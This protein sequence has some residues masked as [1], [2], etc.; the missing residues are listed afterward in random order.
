MPTSVLIEADQDVFQLYTSGVIT[1][2]EDCG[3]SLDHAVLAVGYN[4]IQGQQ[5]FIIKNSW[6]TSWGDDGYV[7]LATT[8][9]AN[10]GAGVCGVLSQPAV[11]K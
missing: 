5:A 10:E 7:Y 9:T 8:Q 3:D 11:P 4:T 1:A 2:A 6:G